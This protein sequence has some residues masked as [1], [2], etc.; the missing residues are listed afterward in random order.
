MSD[1]A[2]WATPPPSARR[3]V[4]MHGLRNHFVIV[5]AR[6]VPFDPGR[7]EIAR[8]CDPQTG[9]GAD[10]LVVIEPAT[11]GAEAFM[12]LYNVDG[13]EVEACGNATR[14][15]AWLMLEEKSVDRVAIETLAGVL[16]CQRAGAQQ[17]SCD[18]GP[19]SL[20][21]QDVPLR[22]AHDTLNVPLRVGPLSAA[23]TLSV[24]N[25]HAVFFVDDAES[26]DLEAL[27]PQ[28]QQDPL[29]PQQVNVGVATLRT[30]SDIVLRVYERG[31][32]LT[33]AC[34][35]GACAAAFAARKKG[36]SD[37]EQFTVTLPGGKVSIEIRDDDHAIMTG[38]VA[39]SFRGTLQERL[40][41]S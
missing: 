31:A 6:K 19:I 34:G 27:A 16:H 38:P 22:E 8:L 5:D 11:A 3:F 12:R 41:T 36:L 9:V 26:I 1:Q 13:R 25:P 7:E 39:Y 24:G 35:S 29:F 2:H 30:A 4:K 28:I 40:P 14:C 32:G 10:Q 20:R 23:V 33:Q 18:M 17:V 15:V 37:A 21:W